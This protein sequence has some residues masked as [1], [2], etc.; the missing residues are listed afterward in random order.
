MYYSI[1]ILGLKSRS[2]SAPPPK[3]DSPASVDK[4]SPVQSPSHNP[5]SPSPRHA[6]VDT[7]HAGYDATDETME[8]QFYDVD[9]VER[10]HK[11][12]KEAAEVRTQASPTQSHSTNNQTNSIKHL[13]INRLTC[14]F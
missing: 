4:D 1:F 3:V 10:I 12:R 7:R 8:I 14:F 9:D 2:R 11:R 5:A 6:W 13:E